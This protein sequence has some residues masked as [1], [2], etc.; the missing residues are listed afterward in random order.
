M[1]VDFRKLNAITK[2]NPYLLPFT[3]E[4]INTVV[5]HEVYTFLDGF[6]KY[7]QISIAPKD[8]HKLLL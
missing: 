8:Q 7:H 5:G 1:C 6:L 2:K 3:D 4:I